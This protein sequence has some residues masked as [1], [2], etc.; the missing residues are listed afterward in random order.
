[1]ALSKSCRL[2]PLPGPGGDVPALARL[3]EPEP[4]E[5]LLCKG[6]GR[7][8]PD[9]GEHPRHVQDGLDHGLPGLG[10]Q[11]IELR[12]V[13]P[14]HVRAV[15]A[16]IDQPGVTGPEIHALERHGGVGLVP[17]VVFEVN[18]DARDL[19]DVGTVERVGGKRRPRVGPVEKPVRV[20]GDPARVHSR[21]IGHH[22]ACKPDPPLART[23]LQP[24]QS[25]SA[26]QL[27]GHHVVIQRIGGGFRV[28]VSHPSLYF[29]R[30]G[31]SFPYP[32][33]PERGES[34]PC[35]PVQ[36]LVGHLVQP[37]YFP[38]VL[39]GELVQP[40]E[41]VLGHHDRARHPLRVRA[42]R[43]Y[44]R[45]HSY[46]FVDFGRAG[47]E[48]AEAQLLL[49]PQQVDAGE[50]AQK[51]VSQQRPP[52]GA[53]ELELPGEG[54][55]SRAHRAAQHL[56]EGLVVRTEYGL[57]AK[58]IRQRIH[59]REVGGVRGKLRVVKELDKGPEG[60][61][62]VCKRYAEHFFKDDFPARHARVLPRK[63]FL[64][65]QPAGLER[66]RGE[67]RDE[68]R[69][70]RVHRGRAQ[71]ILRKGDGL[72]NR[73]LVHARPV[74]ARHVVKDLV[75]QSHGVHVPGPQGFFRLSAC[76]N[77]RPGSCAG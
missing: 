43:L 74:Q 67:L 77:A 55:R 65:R 13:V 7:V 1:M 10:V 57:P 17:V 25:L 76:R 38:A 8:E 63:V 21:V 12:R 27:A 33:E 23:P 46:V 4:L 66:R 59:E 72:C 31:A 48:C 20:L 69:E 14:R 35:Q 68:A 9:D 75:D 32:D 73:C 42:E 70:R 29:A 45:G 54:Q 19:R 34:R 6:H 18:A 60:R 41:G 50:Q 64:H 37:P 39:T 61:V 22:V 16:V 51:E 52:A 26:A 53:D 58:E 28:L 71:P 3:R 24:V 15:I 44:L 5:V 47:G 11:E 30:R 62:G 49:F 40:Y 36:L 56:H 2:R